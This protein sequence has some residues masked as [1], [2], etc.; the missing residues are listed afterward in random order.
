MVIILIEVAYTYVS[1]VNSPTPQYFD[2]SGAAKDQYTGSL[3]QLASGLICR[4]YR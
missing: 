3:P 1:N 2:N 4:C